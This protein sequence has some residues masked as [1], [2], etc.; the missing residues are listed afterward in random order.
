MEPVDDGPIRDGDVIARLFT[1]F[2]ILG[3]D[4]VVNIALEHGVAILATE[5][6]PLLHLGKTLLSIRNTVANTA[7]TIVSCLA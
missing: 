1:P 6:T 3:N 7:K 5:T 2:S 4:V